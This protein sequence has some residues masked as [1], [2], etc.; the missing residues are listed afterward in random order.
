MAA[1]E[2]V[3]AVAAVE[4]QRD[5]ARLQR[6][7]VDRVVAAQAVDVRL[8]LAPS[9]SVMCTVADRPVTTAVLPDAG[10]R[11]GVVAVG[12][13]DD[14]G[15]GLAVAGAAAGR[16]REVE[17]DVGDAGAGQVVDGDGVGAAEGGDVDLLDAVEVH[18]D[19][20]DVAEEP[21]PA[22]VGREVDVLVDVGAVEQHR[23]GAALALDD[24][25]A[26]AGVP[27]EGVVAGAHEGHVVAAA[28]VDEV[29]A[30]AADQHVV[31]VAADDACRCRRRRPPSA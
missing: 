8:S 7:G 31:A 16:A 26:V 15:V 18:G 13:V 29:V 5:H 14:D 17:V 20:A 4:G 21:Q 9:A 3:V 23:V 12:A 11:D 2:D 30:V 24:V 27:H 25:A 22:A 10:D 19:V 1:D 6:G 28:A